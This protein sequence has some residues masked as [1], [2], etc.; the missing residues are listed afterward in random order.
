MYYKHH[1]LAF[2]S[3]YAHRHYIFSTNWTTYIYINKWTFF[4]KIH[5]KVIVYYLQTELH[6]CIQTCL[7]LCKHFAS[8]Y[9]QTLHKWW[10]ELHT[11][12][13]KTSFD[14]VARFSRNRLSL[15]FF[16]KMYSPNKFEHS[17][18]GIRRV[19]GIFLKKGF[20]KEIK[21]TL[22]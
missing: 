5:S 12:Y 18:I 17:Q 21:K 4:F 16:Q 7:H 11:F 6:T 9:I 10:T 8:K 3:K 14:S 19:F 13:I 1:L 22:L 15:V 2:Y 20:I